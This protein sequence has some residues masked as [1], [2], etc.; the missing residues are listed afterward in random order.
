MR[1][2]KRRVTGRAR[3]IF[4]PQTGTHTRHKQ[5]TKRN[6]VA[7]N[8]VA[9]ARDTTKGRSM[10]QNLSMAASNEINECMWLGGDDF[11][12]ASAAAATTTTTTTTAASAEIKAPALGRG[13]LRLLLHHR[14]ERHFEYGP[15]CMTGMEW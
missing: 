3:E 2:A 5:Q 11:G 15:G 6:N 7:C 10:F 14:R 1:N 4:Q 12:G 8:F 9:A 13:C